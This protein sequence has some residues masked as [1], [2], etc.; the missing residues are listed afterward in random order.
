MLSHC[1]SVCVSALLHLVSEKDKRID[2]SFRQSEALRQGLIIGFSIITSLH[3][4]Q[5]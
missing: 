4:V 5:S 3:H 2:E 1:V